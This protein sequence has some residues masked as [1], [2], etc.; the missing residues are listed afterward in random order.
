VPDHESRTVSGCDDPGFNPC[1]VLMACF[2]GL[3]HHR[4]PNDVFNAWKFT[5]ELQDRF[6]EEMMQNTLMHVSLVLLGNSN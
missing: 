6:E 2:A 5:L 4:N 3:E 1:A